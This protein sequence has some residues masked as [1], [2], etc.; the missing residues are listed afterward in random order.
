LTS[1]VVLILALAG[2]F[3]LSVV[4]FFIRL[5]RESYLK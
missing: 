1:S 4:Y 2:F 5:F 3:L